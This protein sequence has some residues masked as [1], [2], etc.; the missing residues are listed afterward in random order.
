MADFGLVEVGLE[1][2]CLF[3]V[4]AHTGGLGWDFIYLPSRSSGRPG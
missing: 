3:L 1:L 4:T 2:A